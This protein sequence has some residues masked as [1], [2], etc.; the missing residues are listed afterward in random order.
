VRVA[1]WVLTLAGALGLGFAALVFWAMAGH[2][3]YGFLGFAGLANAMA[4]VVGAALALV[5]GLALMASARRRR[6]P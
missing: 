5:A 6:G 1:G 3:D 4:F 2:F